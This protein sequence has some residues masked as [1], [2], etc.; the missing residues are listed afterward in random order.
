[1][2]SMRF[3]LACRGATAQDALVLARPERK[4]QLESDDENADRERCEQHARDEGLARPELVACG[5]RSHDQDDGGKSDAD[6]THDGTEQHDAA[7]HDQRRPPAKRG[8]ARARNACRPKH[9]KATEDDEQ[10]AEDAREVARTHARGGTERVAAAK[11]DRK[12]VV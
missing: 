1:M 10:D 4:L 9:E 12:S 2:R 11:E 8:N 7:E 5:T 3:S 6:G